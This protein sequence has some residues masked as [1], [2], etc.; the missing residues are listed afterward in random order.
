LI[1]CEHD[2]EA[3]A[4]GFAAADPFRREQLVDSNWL[5]VWSVE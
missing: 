3:E 4:R 2:S 1:T 5:K